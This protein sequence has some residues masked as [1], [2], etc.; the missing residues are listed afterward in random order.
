MIDLSPGLFIEILDLFKNPSRVRHLLFPNRYEILETEAN[1]SDNKH[2]DYVYET[3][4]KVK[5][6]VGFDD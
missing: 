6:K 4:D 2:N 5:T 3:L 1:V